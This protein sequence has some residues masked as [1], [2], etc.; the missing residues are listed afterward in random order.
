MARS[1]KLYYDFLSPPSRVLWLSL[2]LSKTPFEACPVALRKFEQLTDEYK[3]I[4]RFQKL[5]C[6]IHDGFHL[7]ESIAM[8]RYL[9]DKGQLSELLYPKALK[10]RA[11]ID[12]YLEW[13]HLNVRMP[14]GLYFVHGWLYP[15][16]GIAEKPKPEEAEKL[17]KDVN[18]CLES[19]EHFWL[20]N[21]FIIGSHLTIAD[22]F[23]ASEISQIKLCQ[24]NV[25]EQQFPKVAK[26]FKRVRE[27]SNPYFDEAHEFVYKKSL[28][29][30]KAKL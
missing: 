8:V 14:C 21:E 5:P 16:N 27:A 20:D 2:K 7:S 24:Y 6:L 9:A 17:I 4:N 13:Q 11:R 19:L 18:V 26:W 15:I 29:A 22:L 30:A 3:K 28:Q 23:A 25:N 12:E 10:D 1:L